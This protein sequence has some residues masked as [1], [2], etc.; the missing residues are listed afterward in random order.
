MRGKRV[1]IPYCPAAVNREPASNSV[2][3]GTFGKMEAKAMIYES[4]SLLITRSM[5]DL[6]EIRRWICDSTALFL[7]YSC[8][9]GLL[10]TT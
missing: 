8:E 7:G 4:E 6:R 2:T 9:D 5:M 10:K 1:E 3:E